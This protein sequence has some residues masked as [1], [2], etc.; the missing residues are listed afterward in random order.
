MPYER[1]YFQWRTKKKLKTNKP[2]QKITVLKSIR[3]VLCFQR[4][5]LFKET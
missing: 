4:Y 3:N 2:K 1:F 5:T